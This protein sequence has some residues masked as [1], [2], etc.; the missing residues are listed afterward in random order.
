MVV[1]GN[2]PAMEVRN[3]TKHYIIRHQKNPSL[4]DTIL[5]GREMYEK[6]SALEDITFSVNHGE[7]FGII[8]SNG[9]GKSTLLKIIAKV[10]KPTSGEVIVNGTVSALLE[11]GAGFHTDLTGRENI[12]LNASILGLKRKDINKRFDDIIEFSELEQFIDMPVKSYSSGMYMRLGFSIAIN[13]N[14]DILLVDE[15]LAVGDQSFQSKC[16][17]VIYDFMHR[18]KTIIIVSHDL[19]T[20]SDLCGRVI[21]LK[22]GKIEDMGDSIRVVN[23]YRA[24][25]EEIE[26]QRIIEQQR[27]E[28]KKIFKSII[29]SKRKIIDGEEI[30]RISKLGVGEEFKNRFGSGEAEVTKIEMLDEAGNLIDFCKSDAAVQIAFEVK[31]K[32]IVE[33]PIFGIRITDHRNF[34]V[35]GTNS[36]LLGIKTDAYKHGDKV[37]VIFKQK[38][39]LIGGQYFVTVSVGNKDTKTYHDWII[40]IMTIN[41][42]RKNNSEGIA[43]LNSEVSLKEIFKT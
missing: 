37:R 4:K 6:F 16:Y 43:D 12:Y 13:V 25:V 26:R 35:Y 11:L 15:V 3:V 2:N 1:L 19:D 5:K 41:V 33:N 28:R 34:V 38:I 9:S 20:I 42:L 29:D 18:G 17:K 21:F 7:T 8:G 40:N 36:R 22:K 14:P 32:N 39:N 30:D 27:I 23:R 24:Y 31:F 10:L